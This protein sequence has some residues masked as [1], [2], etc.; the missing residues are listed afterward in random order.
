MHGAKGAIGWPVPPRFEQDQPFPPTEVAEKLFDEA[1]LADAGVALDDHPHHGASSDLLPGARERAEGGVAPDE[2]GREQRR[3]AGAT[4]RGLRRAALLQAPCK[5]RQRWRRLGGVLD[6]QLRGE[7]RVAPQRLDR[8]PAAIEQS[9]EP[10]GGR[11]VERKR[12]DPGADPSQTQ[13][14]SEARATVLKQTL[15][16][17]GVPGDRVA[18]VGLGATRPD[19]KPLGPGG[20]PTSARIEISR[21]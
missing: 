11:L 15:L 19:P 8:A 10:G 1:R 21:L 3:R 17:S 7:R 16:A 13:A 4:A 6:L 18:A 20:V 5:L 9:D 2:V 12:V 14:L